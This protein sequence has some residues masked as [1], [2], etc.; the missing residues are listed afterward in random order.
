MKHTK[1]GL[2]NSIKN[3]VALKIFIVRTPILINAFLQVFWVCVRNPLFLH[4]SYKVSFVICTPAAL[5]C[6]VLLWY[7][8]GI[9]QNHT[10]HTSDLL[11]T[12]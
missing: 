12:Y 1:S 6:Q 8:H 2:S 11:L 3:V 9:A 7:C 5:Y 4:K 10:K